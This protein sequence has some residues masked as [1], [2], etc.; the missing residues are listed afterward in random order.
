MLLVF[1]FSF[2]LTTHS[3]ITVEKVSL[4]HKNSL[5]SHHAIRSS[6]AD[7]A[8][9]SPIADHAIRSPIADHAI[10]SPIA[11]TKFLLGRDIWN[12]ANNKFYVKAGISC[13]F[14]LY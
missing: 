2:H 13:R 12:T 4:S 5:L 6:I 14:I 1:L 8:I 9:R 10:R 3:P 11:I 7:H